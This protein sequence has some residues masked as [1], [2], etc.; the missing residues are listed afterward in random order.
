MLTSTNQN[1]VIM[2]RGIIIGVIAGAGAVLL[3]TLAVLCYK[4]KWSRSTSG[5]FAWQHANK[6]FILGVPVQQTEKIT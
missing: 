4:F 3:V 5:G 6:E 2:S 1:D